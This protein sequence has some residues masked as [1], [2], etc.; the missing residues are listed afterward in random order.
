M[1]RYIKNSKIYGMAYS[2]K[3]V[4]E[5]IHKIKDAL[6]EHILKCAIYGDSTNNLTHW[7]KEVCGY[8]NY[9]NRFSVKPNNGRLKYNDYLDNLFG[10]MGDA[11]GDAETDLL[12]FQ[13][14]NNH[15]KEYPDF[16]IT[17]ELIQR[18]FDIFNSIKEYML[19]ILTTKNNNLGA[20]DFYD[21]IYNIVR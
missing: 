10:F 1:K 2:R 5:N 20:A 21:T 15:S 19:P 4:I 3:D 17:P 14:N 12:W 7:V 13:L 8:L 16:E 6:E 11:I 9:A 18:T